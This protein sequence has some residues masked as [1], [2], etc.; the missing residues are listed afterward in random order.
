MDVAALPANTATLQQQHIDSADQD[1]LDDLADEVDLNGYQEEEEEE[2]EEEEGGQH[3]TQRSGSESF[4][5]PMCAQVPPADSVSVDQEGQKCVAETPERQ[6][7]ST[8]REFGVALSGLDAMYLSF[9]HAHATNTSCHAFF[10]QCWAAGSAVACP[11]KVVFA[12]LVL[13]R[14]LVP[15]STCWSACGTSRWCHRRW[16]ASSRRSTGAGHT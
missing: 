1:Q 5:A 8:G 11:W 12:C 10:S 15:C 2:Q 9:E 7:G 13:S 6:D 14:D 16:G 3:G 4:V